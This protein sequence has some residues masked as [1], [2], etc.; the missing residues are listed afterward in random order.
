[1][2]ERIEAN[3][4]PLI[5][6]SA[7]LFYNNLFKLGYFGFDLDGSVQMQTKK[8]LSGNGTVLTRKLPGASC[9]LFTPSV[10]LTYVLLMSN[11]DAC[12]TP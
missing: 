9:N 3:L 12:T 6:A 1:M 2:L 11:R 4:A 10:A 5:A 8:Q 7:S